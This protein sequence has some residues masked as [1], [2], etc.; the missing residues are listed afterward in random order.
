MLK[1][2]EYLDSLPV[3]E[4]SEQLPAPWLELSG[5]A[6]DVALEDFLTMLAE[7]QTHVGCRLLP[8]VQLDEQLWAK[9]SHMM[10][11]LLV[12]PDDAYR[13]KTH[14]ITLEDLRQRD[15][16]GRSIMGLEL[17]IE[18]FRQYPAPRLGDDMYFA[19]VVY[20]KLSLHHGRELDAFRD[21][22]DNYRGLV[23]KLL[24]LS[25]I[26]F[27]MS[28]VIP[29]VEAV[30]SKKP[31]PRL[32]AFLHVKD[33]DPDEQWF[34]LQYAWYPKRSYQRGL[35]AF[36]AQAILFTCI[37]KAAVSTRARRDYI[38]DM[39]NGLKLEELAE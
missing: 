1:T 28:S 20:T 4:A 10:G 39:W 37:Q 36:V 13:R 2:I 19:S 21:I 38:L 31:L 23:G 32:D 35:R 17:E 30:R 33:V 3:F 11:S 9:P 24:G 16:G 7:A 12:Y 27:S 14:Q 22:Y 8:H 34:D 15:R 18:L 25:D 26:E 5:R 29:E 6:I